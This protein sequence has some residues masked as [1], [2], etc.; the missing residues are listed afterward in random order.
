MSYEFEPSQR[1]MKS[2]VWHGKQC[3]FVSTIN[4]QDSTAYAYW[5]SETMAW[6]WDW[7]THVRGKCVAQTSGATDS[8]TKHILV[9]EALRKDGKYEEEL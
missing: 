1:V 9:C 3:Y 4:R 5:F 8:I 7:D 2:H 6:E